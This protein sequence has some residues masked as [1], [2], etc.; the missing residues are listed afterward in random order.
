MKLI[1]NGILLMFLLSCSANK[2][3]QATG[4]MPACLQEKINA[5]I[6]EPNGSP[7]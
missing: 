2:K 1:Y 7:Q 5:M 3:I 6:A 4:E